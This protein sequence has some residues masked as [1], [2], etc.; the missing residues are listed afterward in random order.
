[1]DCVIVL[2]V[3]TKEE[4]QKLADR[5]RELRGK[6]RRRKSYFELFD[7][8]DEDAESLQ[9][10]RSD[11][12]FEAVSPPL[13]EPSPQLPLGGTPRE[14]RNT[15][16]RRAFTLPT[17]PSALC[18]IFTLPAH[19]LTHTPTDSR[20]A[21]DRH[22]TERLERKAARKRERNKD[23]KDRDEFASDDSEDEYV[24]RK[25]RMLEAPTQP[26]TTAGADADFVGSNRERRRE[27]EGEQVYASGSGSGRRDEEYREREG[28]G[29]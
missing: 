10:D 4:I 2:R 26:A 18:N 24:E 29:Y 11:S 5:T 6:Q 8:D 27:R 21:S 3:L 23:R 7:D 19:S 14:R 15:P 25:P 13:D 16:S 9:A 28:D 20:Q 17:L 22:E 1:M 12:F